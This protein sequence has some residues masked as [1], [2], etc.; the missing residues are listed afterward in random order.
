[1]SQS[2]ESQLPTS[3]ILTEDHQYVIFTPITRQEFLTWFY[4]TAWYS[5]ASTT[6]HSLPTFDNK[7]KQSQTWESFYVIANATTGQC[8]VECKGCGLRQDHPSTRNKG[9]TSSLITH[10]Q[11]KRCKDETAKKT[12]Q[13]QL[14]LETSLATGNVRFSF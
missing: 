14:T 2:T 12:G 4:T 5:N 13:G 6:T 8:K 1:M 7:K 3:L 9:G 11:S 10:L